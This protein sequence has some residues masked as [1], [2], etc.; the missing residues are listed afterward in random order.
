[1][2]QEFDQEK[3]RQVGIRKDLG[4]TQKYKVRTYWHDVIWQMAHNKISLIASV[5]ILLIILFA[6]FVPM[7]SP[8]SYKEVD[9]AHT[10]LS[11]CL[12]HPF[13]TDDLGR[14]I[15]T[16]CA[17]GTR[18]SLLVALVAVVLDMGI[19]V[20]YGLISGYFGGITDLLMQRFVEIISGIPTMVIVTLLLLVMKPGVGSIVIALAMTGW[21]NMSRIVRAQMLKQKSMEYVMA[22]HTLGEKHKKIIVSEILPNTVGQIIIT[23]MFTI[24][25]A[26]FFEAFLA[27]IG[28]GVQAPMASLGS[29]INDGY[30][31]AMM[32]PYM[33]FTPCLVLGL[34]MLCFNL[35]ADGLKEAI[36]PQMKN[37]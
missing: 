15:M 3:F 31:S 21:I 28:L 24:P 1:M 20:T 19:G 22:A 16:R 23:F 2:V 37:M 6:I 14:D 13:G 26:I 32:Y 17:V 4:E 35:L 36:D 7:F 34:L 11:P 18:I 10:F 12:S 9:M 29:M 33:V 5:V 8:Y 27:F 25:N 30:K